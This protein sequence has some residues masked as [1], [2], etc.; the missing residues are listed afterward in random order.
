[1]K[2]D[3]CVVASDLN[4]KYSEFLPLVKHCWQTKVGV[5]IKCIL[6]SNFIPDELKLYSDDIILF[7]PIE[8]VPTAF[9][10]Q[11]IR[12]LYPCILECENGVII[13]DMDLI[14][15]NK[16]YYLDNI[17]KYSN[18]NFIVYRNVIEEYKQYPICFCVSTPRIWK[19]IFNINN[20]QDIRNKIEYWF[21]NLVP[22]NDYEISSPYSIGWALDQI[23]LFKSV[24]D[25]N[26][27]TNNLIKLCDD[28]SL[29]NRLDRNDV[30]KI[31]NNLDNYINKIN[32]GEYSDFHLPRPYIRYKYLLDILVGLK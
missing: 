7:N 22:T 12:I 15:L 27:K 1:M 32:N 20:I 9:Q 8:N 24:N 23:E 30:D 28:S 29:F 13:S 2:I 18:D 21:F 17:D 11:C 19:E 26:L 3:L 25:W 31:I 10:A 4:R 14:P 16:S 5:N 6:I